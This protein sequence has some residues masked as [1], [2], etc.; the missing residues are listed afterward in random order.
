M[1]NNGTATDTPFGIRFI[2]NNTESQPPLETAIVAAA[3]TVVAN[4]LGVLDPTT[5][6]LVP[7]TPGADEKIWCLILMNGSAGDVVQIMPLFPGYIL[8]AQ[9]VSSTV[10]AQ[11]NIGDLC[12]VSGTTGTTQ[13]LNVGTTTQSVA[14]LL[15]LSKSPID[16]QFGK[17]C[18]LDFAILNARLKTGA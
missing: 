14:V 15:N 16:N 4:T 11:A 9:S 2:R 5:G 6:N 17:W 12:E 8:T 10:V 7:H 18:N 1:A 13:G 3:N